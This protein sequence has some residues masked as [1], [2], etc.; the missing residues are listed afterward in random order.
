MAVTRPF[1][2]SARLSVLFITNFRPAPDLSAGERRLVRMCEL[3]AEMADL[4]LVAYAD[5]VRPEA[6]SRTRSGLSGEVRSAGN[7]EVRLAL[8][9]RYYDLVVFEFWQT[10]E[11]Y[12][13]QARQ[14][15]PHACLVVDTVD[16]DFVRLARG[17]EV[18]AVVDA[19]LSALRDRE[20]AAYSAAD[21]LMFCSA[22]EESLYRQQESD[23]RPSVVVSII[24]SAIDVMSSSDIPRVLFV[25][26][27]L[28]VPNVDGISW[29]CATAWPMIRGAIPSAVLEL[30][31]SN[32][33]DDIRALGRLEGV[34]VRGFVADIAEVYG[35]ASVVVAPLR[36]GAGVKGKV[37]EA[38]AASIPVVTTSL[39]ME[40]LSLVP[41][42]DLVVADDAAGLAEGTVRLLTNR[43]DAER[44]GRSGQQ[45]VLRLCGSEAVQPGLRYLLSLSRGNKGR[46]LRQQL[47]IGPISR[48]L[49]ALLPGL[50]WVRPSRSGRRQGMRS[51]EASAS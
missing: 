2:R 1:R 29:F 33:S 17:A 26:N 38:L 6:G 21:A 51:K 36:F 30:V 16:L 50:R 10:A 48:L 47:F 27:F 11:R 28:H 35:G 12:L 40:G 32:M 3:L 34:H 41:G 22:E 14:L 24:V 18:G 45:A 8:K 25:G 49:I 46:T 13:P 7:L 15:Q 9:A 42:R 37:C 31:G 44:I 23:P 43:D 5:D 39:G 4:R 20:L 19:P